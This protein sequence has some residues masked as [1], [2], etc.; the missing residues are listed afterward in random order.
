MTKKTPRRYFAYRSFWPELTT[1]KHFHEVGID[2]ICF[3][4]A[5]TM[6]SV[7]EP[8]CKY[9]PI[10][11]WYDQFDF[12]PLDRQ[13]ADILSANPDA[14]FLCIIDLNSPHWLVRHQSCSLNE[15]ESFDG[16]TKAATL[17]KW[18]EATT[19][20]LET[21]LRYTENKYADRIL[22]YVLACGFTDEWMDYTNGSSSESK[23]AAFQ[24]WR[25]Q[26]D[27]EPRDAPSP[28]EYNHISFDNFLLDPSQDRLALDYWKFT[29]DT[30]SG[31]IEHFAGITRKLIRPEVEIGVFYGYILELEC[32]RLS[33]C[34][35]LAYE[36]LM[37]QSE[38]DFFISPGDYHDRKM[39][40]GSGF[41][42]PHGTFERHNKGFLHECD[43]RTHSF[44]PKLSPYVNYEFEHWPDEASDIAGMRR[45]MALALINH[46]SLWW[47]DM[48]GGYYQKPATYANLRQMKEF[49]DRFVN[50][51]TES[52]TEVAMIVDPES[53]YYVGHAITPWDAP[54]IGTHTQLNRLGAPYEIFSF[55]DIPHIAE[56]D[57]YKLIIL[58][59]QFEITAEKEAI[60]RQHVLK[61]KRT[62]LW[63]YAP[64]ISDGQNLHPD[65]V[66]E[67]CGFDFGKAGLSCVS[68][69]TWN[70]AYI[71]DYK[72]L[73]PA[74]LKE[75]AK[76]AGV[77]LY[78]ED[79]VPVYANS[80]LLAI[81]VAQGGEKQ[82]TLPA[83]C[84]EVIE[85]YTGKV[86]AENAKQF[87]WHF[88]TPDTALFE[89]KRK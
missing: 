28:T 76:H 35:H 16:L 42:L 79:P 19:Q 66:R 7:G 5:N 9:P 89:I 84:K 65:R 25:K 58:P 24:E 77:T 48:W 32:G 50:V 33:R 75:V 57:R 78:C 85:L 10:W 88:Q 18:K 53:A 43:Q 60:L 55:N 3:F 13:I 23:N 14:K 45:E 8:Y 15:A 59:A 6:N 87:V 68:M 12:E 62:V 81:H 17:P 52:V 39:G 47:F 26:N 41:F 34:G 40:G 11:R 67:L 63:L 70:S 82:I 30:V 54:F 37:T 2:T 49:W 20:Y 46:T 56:L 36:R 22:A 74:V 73:T 38:V 61:N 72:A 64:G 69:G 44:N 29:G 80:R 27:L 86:A 71:H 1:M 31:A 4:A 51:P 21:F 83:A